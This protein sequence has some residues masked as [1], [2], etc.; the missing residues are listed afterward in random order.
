MGKIDYDLTKIKGIVF[1]MDG[2]LS[3][4]TITLSENGTPLRMGNVKDGYA[5][6]LASKTDLKI[7]VITGG[8]S[9]AMQN[10]MNFLGIEDVFQ[11]VAEKLPVLKN[12]VESRGLTPEEVA[13]MGDDIPDLQCMRYVGLPTAPF[14]AAV[15]VRDTAL[16]VSKFAGGYGCVRDLLREILMAQKNWVGCCEDKD[17]NKIMTW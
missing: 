2:V 3:P 12:W 9:N 11:N 15:E 4:S 7:A 14:D 16:F 1:D 13:Y 6:Q 8:H 10:R 5:M 17:N